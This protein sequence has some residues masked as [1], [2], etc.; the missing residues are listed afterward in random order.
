MH[1]FK[2]SSMAALVGAAQGILYGCIIPVGVAK[3]VKDSRKFYGIHRYI[4]HCA[5]IFATAWL[6][7]KRS[8]NS[9]ALVRLL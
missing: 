9:K 7:C 1:G 8:L 2:P 4:V 5:V 3:P 6:S